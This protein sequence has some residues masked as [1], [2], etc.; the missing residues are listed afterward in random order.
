MGNGF[1]ISSDHVRNRIVTSIT[2]PTDCCVFLRRADYLI[3]QLIV[4]ARRF[5]SL[6]AT[7]LRD[8]RYTFQVTLAW[9]GIVFNLTC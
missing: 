7:P 8:S 9:H 6:D 4:G 5:A 1:S 3:I 2:V